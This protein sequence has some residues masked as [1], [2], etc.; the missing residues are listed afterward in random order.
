MDPVSDPS[1]HFRHNSVCKGQSSNLSQ[2]F[3]TPTDIQGQTL[4]NTS[5]M[6]PLYPSQSVNHSMPQMYL[7]QPLNLSY[8]PPN[9]EQFLN[10]RRPSM[11]PV[12]HQT[13]NQQT[14]RTTST[15]EDEEDS[16]DMAQKS[17]GT[18]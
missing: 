15:S 12:P 7:S 4:P 3:L 17:H 8:F 18:L 5:Q 2:M 6:P 9:Q 11:A 13:C 16:T 10:M 1:T 14:S